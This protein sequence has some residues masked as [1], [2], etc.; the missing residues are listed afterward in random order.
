M[1]K[2]DTNQEDGYT[3]RNRWNA[4]KLVYINIGRQQQKMAEMSSKDIRGFEYNDH[5]EA[6][7]SPSFHADRVYA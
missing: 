7:S 5:L 2:R 3:T 1:Y 6:T 4:Q